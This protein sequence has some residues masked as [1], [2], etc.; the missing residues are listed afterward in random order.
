MAVLK[1]RKKSKDKKTD[2]KEEIAPEEPLH[3]ETITWGDLTWVNIQPPTQREIDY[4]ARNYPFHPLDL[5]DCL[6]RK[7]LPKVDEY[8]E[9]LFAIFHLPVFDKTTRVTNKKQWSAFVGEK[10]LV[11]LHTGELRTLVA[12]FNDCQANED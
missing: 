7:Q 4:L 11:T 8:P 5:D 3:V 10:F 1:G 12:L 9:Y 6:S 2:I